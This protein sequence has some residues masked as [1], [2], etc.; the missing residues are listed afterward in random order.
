MNRCSALDVAK[1]VVNHSIG[2]DMTHLRLQKTLYYLYVLFYRR[3][4]K[5]LFEDDFL[6]YDYGP[7]VRSVY[8]AYKLFGS[9]QLP[10]LGEVQSIDAESE[11]KVFLEEMTHRLE[12]Y[13]V[14]DLVK[15]THDFSP[16]K[17]TLRSNIIN[18]SEIK[19]YHEK[20][21]VMLYGKK[22]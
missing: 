11:E 12:D 1:F 8:D 22:G 2:G 7:V 18:K 15:S 21:G 6:A 3:Y 17:D 14:F 20:N 5:E 13:K 19:K 10:K 4:K 9:S 16:W